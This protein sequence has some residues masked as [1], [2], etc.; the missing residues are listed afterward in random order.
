MAHVCRCCR[1]DGQTQTQL[2]Q[3]VA[4]RHCADPAPQ[5]GSPDI[6]LTVVAPAKCDNAG[7]AEAGRAELRVA[8]AVHWAG[9]PEARCAVAGHLNSA[10]RDYPHRTSEA[11][12]W[13][14]GEA[15]TR[16]ALRAACLPPPLGLASSTGAGVAALPPVGPCTA[17]APSMRIAT[18]ASIRSFYLPLPPHPALYSQTTLRTG[19]RRLF[20]SPARLL[21]LSPSWFSPPSFAVALSSTRLL[22]LPSPFFFPSFAPAA[23]PAL[24]TSPLCRRRLFC[25]LCGG[26][27][28]R[29]RGYILMGT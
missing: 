1:V 11:Q 24:S 29:L 10:A 21:A 18:C 7:S 6:A 8:P 16:G 13:R 22:P 14:G 25:P 23:P 3:P 4:W 5:R 19:R 26:G 17:A 12:L 20:W 28:Q 9:A 15:T 27:A 2:Q